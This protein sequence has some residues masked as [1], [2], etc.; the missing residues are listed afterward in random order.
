MP[1]NENSFLLWFA[2]TWEDFTPV[3]AEPFLTAAEANEAA[4]RILDEGDVDTF[5]SVVQ[6]A[7]Q[8]TF[9]SISTDEK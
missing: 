9:P 3:A 6:S 7:P 8:T 1:A 4:Q 5:V 2:V